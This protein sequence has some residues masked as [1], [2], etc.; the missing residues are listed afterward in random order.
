M[1]ERNRIEDAMA[2]MMLAVF[3]A[4]YLLKCAK[5]GKVLTMIFTGLK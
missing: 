4:L 3:T 1:A 2:P 5:P